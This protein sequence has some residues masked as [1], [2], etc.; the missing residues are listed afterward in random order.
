MAVAIDIGEEEDIHPRNKPDVGHRLARLALA[1]DYGKKVADSGPVLAE[2]E[3]KRGQ[4]RL[5]FDEVGDGLCAAD[6]KALQGFALAGRNRKWAWAQARI[7][8]KKTL[9]VTSNQVPK[10]VA[11]RYGWASNPGSNLENSH[12]LPAAPFRTD[13]WPRLSDGHL[14]PF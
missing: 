3:F 11:V 5:V 1:R 4:A 13:G 6:G 9:V 7:L 12:S 10:P 8:D 14:W 2:A